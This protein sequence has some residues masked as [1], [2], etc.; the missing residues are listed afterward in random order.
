MPMRE[1]L[2]KISIIAVLLSLVAVSSC[3]KDITVDLPQAES[4]LVVDGYVDFDDYPVVFLSKSTAYFQELDTNA[5]NDLQINDTKATVIVSDGSI[6]DTLQYLPIQRWPYKCFQGTKFKGKLN[7]RYDLKILYEGKTYTSSTYI[8]DT[9]K[10]DTVFP[11]F[12]SD[13]FAV[14]RI[15]WR[16]PKYQSNYYTI[17]VKNQFQPMYY[18]PYA[19]NHIISDKL[20]DGEEMSFAMVVKG[21]ERNAYYDNFFT[22]EERDSFINKLGDIFCFREGDSVSL[23]LSTIDNVSYNIWESWYRNWITDG[24]PFTNPATVRTNINAPEGMEA[25]GFW[26]GYGCNY[27]SIY[28]YSKDSVVPIGGKF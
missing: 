15:N 18:R 24:N 8:P 28:L 20:A 16:D 22:Q 10:I 12:M 7:H 3:I 1:S 9:I 11:T 4:C 21:M 13:T 27:R 25:K 6:S 17:H 5:V 19:L 2:L 23:K 26:I 14:M